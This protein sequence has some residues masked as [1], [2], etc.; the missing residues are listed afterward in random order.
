[1]QAA[2]DNNEQGETAGPARELVQSQQKA[3]DA[4]GQEWVQLQAERDRL[5]R[6]AAL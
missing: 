1:M 2:K 6:E 5:E 4:K 3:L